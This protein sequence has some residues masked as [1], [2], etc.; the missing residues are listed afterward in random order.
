ML[1]G[2]LSAVVLA[3]AVP[4]AALPGDWQ[5]VWVRDGASLEVRFH[6]EARAGELRGSFDSDP[7]RAAGIPLSALQ[8][9]EQGVHFELAGDVSTTRFDGAF[10]GDSLTGTFEDGEARGTFALARAAARREPRQEDVSFEDG[11]VTLAGTLVRPASNGLA[12]AVVFVHGS[13][14]EGRW[15]SRYLAFTL[16]RAGIA[17]LIYDKRGVGGSTGDWRSAGFEELA[18][19]ARAAVR[20]LRTRPGI[21]SARVGIHG[22]S[23]GG[24][25]APLVAARNPEVKFVVAS[26][27]DGVSMADCEIYSYSNA[28]GVPSLHGPDS[29][30]AAD[31]V[32]ELISV[33]YD[34]APR[35]RLDSL[36]AAFKDRP[37]FAP[38]PAPDNPWWSIS[39]RISGYDP[40]AWWRLV[41]V[42][43]LLLYGEAD[44]RVPAAS[45]LRRI[46]AALAQG[47]NFRV[48]RQVFA[49]ADHTFRLPGAPGKFAWP[50]TAP[51][52]PEVI[53][54]WISKLEG[55]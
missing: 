52:Y 39:Q 28:L 51:G 13:G 17:S 26:S 19:D 33:G 54:D 9:T 30:M 31:Y 55:R 12:P 10:R 5:G 29:A 42:P 34:G 11:P 25:L 8:A 23:Q 41:R 53:P 46:T 35:G 49:G 18:A 37:W 27:G 20:F 24:T 47:G 14:P 48:T 6:F 4:D 50:R 40:T 38:P 15:A 1:V 44:Q 16:A 43:V 22:H 7:L 3:A 45:S 36:A 2:L 21:D 32:R